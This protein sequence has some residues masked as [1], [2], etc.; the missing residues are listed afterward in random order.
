MPYTVYSDDGRRFVIP[1]NML[2]D[3]LS[4]GYSLNKP[5]KGVE[6]EPTIDQSPFFYTT[7]SDEEG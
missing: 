1:T 6:K 3:V 5:K 4:R 7:Y 2:D